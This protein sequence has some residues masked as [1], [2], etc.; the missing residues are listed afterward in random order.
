MRGPVPMLNHDILGDDDG[1]CGGRNQ[2][3]VAANHTLLIQN[4][5][6]NLRAFLN[7]GIL[8][9]DG[10]FDDRTLG[11]FDTAEEHRID[12]RAFNDTP[13]GH[14]RIGALAF[15]DIARGQIVAH[16]GIN[17]ALGGEEL[18]PHVA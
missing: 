6:V 8:H 12:H 18:T 15:L 11:H 14:K 5:V 16:L 10:V 9:D 17:R 13:I 4:A 7:M 3:A 1:I 2:A